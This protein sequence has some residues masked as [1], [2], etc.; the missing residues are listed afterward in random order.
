MANRDLTKL[1]NHR[2]QIHYQIRLVKKRATL[3]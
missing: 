2:A 3:K 1:Q